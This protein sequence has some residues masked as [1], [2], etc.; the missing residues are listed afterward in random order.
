M[1]LTATLRLEVVKPLNG[2]WDLLGSQ[3]RAIQTPLHRVLN[4]VVTDLEV[5][6][7]AGKYNKG[8]GLGP[9]GADLIPH[10]DCYRLTK[11]SW[12][13]E[14]KEA[15]LRVEKG[16]GYPGDDI[17]GVLEPSSSPVLGVAGAA[18]ARWQKWRKE[19]WKGTMS[20][21]T[22]KANS[23]IY[24]AGAGV[25]LQSEDGVTIL[26]LRLVQ[27]PWTEILVC[28][29]HTSG[30]SALRKILSDPECIGDVRL[31]RENHDGK[32]K[33]QAFLS[34]SFEVAAIEKGRTMALHRGLRNFLSLAVSG[35]GTKEAYTTILETGEDVQRHKEI[36]QLRRRSLASQGRQLG[37]GAKGH[38]HT[39][40]YERLT[41]LEDSEERWVT[42]KCQEVAAHAI[43]IG[44][45]RG[46][47][48]ILIEDWTN[49][50]KDGAPELGEHV[51][52]LV[53]Q[54]PLARLRDAI[55]WAAQKKGWT[56]KEVS[57]AYNSRTC[58]HCNEVNEPVKGPTFK[59]SKCLLERSV[60]VIY[61]W[62]MLLNEGKE[63][64]LV[65]AKK[66][67]KRAGGRMRAKSSQA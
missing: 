51:E 59:C 62:N 30:F 64:P 55:T 67:A 15:L 41:K 4:T 38:G 12:E 37:A 40:R 57:S 18:F 63:S 47:N 33:W 49:P 20:L 60:D 3:L 43:R 22:F 61:V 39:R 10:T 27:G 48:Q 7:R 58:P 8:T 11:A 17:I 25:K 32:K 42:T 36:Y 16:K 45:Q 53:R 50:A 52:R 14:R 23:P 21:P 5:N 46:V 34:Y 24:V 54:F 31:S 26:K 56:V 44:E 9:G 35:E 2:D 28:P 13:H 6:S 29:Y 19:A 66:A 1:K 65:D